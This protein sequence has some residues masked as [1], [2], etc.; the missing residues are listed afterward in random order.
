MEKRLEEAMEKWP[1]QLRLSFLALVE[2]KRMQLK[3]VARELLKTEAE[4]MT[5]K[6]M[7]VTEPQRRQ[8]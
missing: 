3:P 4:S 2:S 5:V 8:A 1:E 7:H 6:G